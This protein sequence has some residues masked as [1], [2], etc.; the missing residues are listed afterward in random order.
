MNASETRG[1]KKIL[2]SPPK[3]KYFLVFFHSRVFPSASCLLIG[4]WLMHSRKRSKIAAELSLPK[5]AS[6][7]SGFRPEN[8]AGVRFRFCSQTFF[9]A[10]QNE[11]KKLWQAKFFSL[12][13]VAIVRDTYLRN[14]PKGEQKI[15]PRNRWKSRQP[16]PGVVNRLRARHL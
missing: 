16:P 13:M 11:E 2:L 5:T 1:R 12:R 14:N 8:G 4:Y 10:K 7:W 6:S 15:R 9:R 3:L